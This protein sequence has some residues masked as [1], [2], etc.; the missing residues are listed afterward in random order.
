[1][2]SELDKLDVILVKASWCP[3][4]VNF[5]PIYEKASEEASKR[6]ELASIDINF[7]SY[8]LDNPTE[9]EKFKKDYPG[10]IDHLSGYPTVYFQ[11][12]DGKTKKKKTEFIDHSVVKREGE[13]GKKEA[14]NEFI[15]NIVNKYKSIMSGGTEEY[16]RVQTG[17]MEKFQTSISE[18]LY[19]QKY[20]KYKS[21]YLQIKNT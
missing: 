11:M 1:M 12:L 3:H 20:L 7:Y 15:D 18:V 13:I 19:K 14:V 8:E 2:S 17:G 6:P 5:T 4:C 10:L 16:I 21:K 9:Q